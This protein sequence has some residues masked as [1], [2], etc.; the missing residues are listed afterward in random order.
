MHKRNS[1][2]IE[3]CLFKLFNSRYYSYD[4]NTRPTK[5]YDLPPLSQHDMFNEFTSHDFYYVSGF[6][7]DQ[8]DE[9]VENMILIPD[10]IVHKKLKLVVIRKHLSSYSL[11]YGIN[12]THGMM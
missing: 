8:F 11:E 12:L 2:S 4:K 10:K 7:P 9:I 1:M 6:W 3:T 5:S